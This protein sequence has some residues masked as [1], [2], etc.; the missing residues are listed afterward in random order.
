M[1]LDESIRYFLDKLASNSPEPSGG[2]AAALVGALGAALVSMVANLTV[3]K[4]KYRDVQKE[5]IALLEMSEGLRAQ[6]QDLIAKDT[7]AYGALAAVYKMPRNTDSERAIRTDLMQ[8]SLKAAC[9]VPLDIARGALDVAKLAQTAA[10]IGNSAAV[11]DAG[12][13]VVLAVA[14]AEAA[15]LNVR[16]NLKSIKDNRYTDETWAAV[17]HILKQVRTLKEAVAE[18]TYAKIG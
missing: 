14:C 12:V 9:Q 16:I 4:E 8:G 18:T 3:G 11:S 1:Y 7:E 2:S 10:G 17:Q 15:A 13:A 6:M 5:N